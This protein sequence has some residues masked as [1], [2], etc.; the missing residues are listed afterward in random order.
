MFAIIQIIYVNSN[1]FTTL[2]LS[3]FAEIM[4]ILDYLSYKSYQS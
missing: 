3:E 4:T 1:Y 2:L